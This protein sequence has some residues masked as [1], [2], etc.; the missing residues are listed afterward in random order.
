MDQAEREYWEHLPEFIPIY[1][2]HRDDLLAGGCWYPERVTALDWSLGFPDHV[3]SSG[4]IAK[5]H[6]RAVFLRRGETEFIV[7]PEHVRDILTSKV[8]K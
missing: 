1:R 4:T 7:L 8:A 6:V 5:P 2:A 3:L